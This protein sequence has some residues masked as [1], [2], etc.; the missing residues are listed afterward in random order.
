MAQLVEETRRTGTKAG[1]KP[2]DVFSLTGAQDVRVSPDGRTVAFVV[3]SV[4]RDENEYRSTIWL[5]PLEGSGEPRQFTGGPKADALPRWSPDGTEL[6]FV[7]NRDRKEKQLYV[8]PVAGGEPRRLTDLDGEV[9]EVQW[10]P[11]GSRLAFSAR[12]PDEALKEEDERRRPPRRFRRLQYKLDNVGWIEGRRQH[13]YTVAA[14][15]SG[16]PVQLTHGDFDDAGPAWSPD[17]SRIAFASSRGEDWDVELVSDIHVVDAD[18]GEPEQITAGGALV[19]QPAWSPDGSRIAYQHT[20]FDWDYPRHTQIAVLELPGGKQRVLTASLDRTC[21]PYPPLREPIWDGDDVVFSV[22]DRGNTHVYRVAADGSREPELVVGGD[23]NVTSYDLVAGELVHTATTATALPE[24]FRGDERLTKVADGLAAERELVEPERFVATSADGSEVEAWIIRPAGFEPGARYPVLLNIHGG[25]F[26][27]Y[28]NRFFDE[29]QVYAGAGYA[30]VYSNPRGS[31]GYSEEW[32]R[33]IRG[34]VGGGPGW[35]SVDY[36]DLMAV[37]D[38]ALRRFDFC[39]P[40]RLGVMGGSYGGFMTSW[41]VSHTD[42]FRAACS[43]RAVN[44]LLS[45]FGSS[46]IGWLSKVWTGVFP[47]EDVK[48]Y[49]DQ[50]PST[51]AERITTPLLIMHSENDLRCN[52]EQAEHLFTILRVLRRDVEF[53]RFPAESH[54]LTRSGSPVHRHMRFEILLDWFGKYLA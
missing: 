18:G 8:I 54:E 38:E 49:L 17:G 27:Q 11:D 16:E 24:V 10:S 53:V 41:I 43:E 1:M 25:P 31:S 26:T 32:G 47:W 23:L 35:G 7:S 12:I 50:S 2:E 19:A 34:P 40:D 44:N 48:P 6:A 5:A 30:V 45:E 14:D 22:E 29:F 9:T 37:M 51:Y 39:D 15:G 4:D 3:W 33:A 13:V 36:E 46:D 42:R 28:G 20:P 52:V 21:A